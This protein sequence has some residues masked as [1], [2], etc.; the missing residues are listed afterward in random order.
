MRPSR[1]LRFGV[2]LEQFK[3]LHQFLLKF[4]H[5]GYN[6]NRIY[7]NRISLTGFERVYPSNEFDCPDCG[8]QGV[9]QGWDRLLLCSRCS[10]TGAVSD[11]E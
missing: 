7:V 8:G 5:V 10:A 2:W 1:R 11:V 3:F 6:G 4:S 9:V